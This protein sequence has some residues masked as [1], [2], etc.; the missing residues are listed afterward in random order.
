MKPA[1]GGDLDS[2]VLGLAGPRNDPGMI[3]AAI[4]GQLAPELATALALPYGVPPGCWLSD[5]LY[6]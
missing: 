2:V 3:G 4:E 5:S 6:L 1:A